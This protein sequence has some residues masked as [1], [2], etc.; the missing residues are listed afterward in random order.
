MRKTSSESKTR[1][2]TG[3]VI[4]VI[5]CAVLLFSHI[6]A[7]LSGAVVLLNVL[8][9]YE[10]FQAAHMVQD[11]RNSGRNTVKAHTLVFFAMTRYCISHTLIPFRT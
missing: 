5:I 2:I 7:V 8:A 9:V 4:A 1:I 10:I 6:P 3:I 11:S